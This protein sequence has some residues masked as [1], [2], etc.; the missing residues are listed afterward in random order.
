MGVLGNK[1]ALGRFLL[2]HRCSSYFP[3]RFLLS[4]CCSTYFLEVSV[5]EPDLAP[6]LTPSPG[7]FRPG[8]AK[9]PG[10]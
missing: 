10:V 3:V 8:L 4:H 6:Q 1:A 9:A 2:S 7:F 5:Q